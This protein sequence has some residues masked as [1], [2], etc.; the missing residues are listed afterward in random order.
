MIH[1]RTRHHWTIGSLTA[2]A[3]LTAAAIQPAAAARLTRGPY[4]Q[5][6]TAS[7]ITIRWRTDVATDARVQLGLSPA[8]LTT[9][10]AGATSGTEHSVTLSGLTPETRYYYS[11]G[12]AAEVLGGGTADYTFHT[13]PAPGTGRP[14][15][16]WVIGDSG[17]PGAD[18][19][20]V[21]NAFTGWTGSRDP[22]VWLMLGDNAYDSGTDSEY[23]EAVFDAYPELLRRVVLWPTR[24]NH[25][26]VGSGTDYYDI[27]TM[28]TAAQAGGVPSGTEAYYSFDYGDVHFIC[29]DSEG[30]SRS[31]T[32]AMARWVRND[33]SATDRSWII[34]YFHHP[35]YTKGSHDSDS[36][37]ELRDMR[38]NFV[39]I[40]EAGGVDL[41]LTGHSH[42]YERSF[43]LNGHTGT[44]GSLTNAMI[45]D[46]GDGRARGDGA[47][48]KPRGKVENRGAIY[49][50]A[51]SSSK[52][53][54]GSLDHPAMV[55]SLL[56]LGSM[57]LD[58]EG[59][60]LTARF[61]DENGAVLD[62]FALDK[63][64]EPPRRGGRVPTGRPR[65]NVSLTAAPNP[66]GGAGARLEY[67]LPAAGH[68]SVAVFGVDGR[69][70][71]SL[72]EGHAG[73]GR[74]AVDW[75]GRDASGVPVPEGIY[76][77]SVSFDGEVRV[78][79]LAKLH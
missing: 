78:R 46:G 55:V 22:D 51:G 60:T 27:F 62:D 52:T 6:G 16:I 29:L 59:T 75:N 49:A 48:K 40:L 41:V 26:D 79:R 43:L 76:F 64:Q 36:E 63:S 18:Q 39:P 58:V 65:G 47:Y 69:R 33:I 11:V 56:R 30:S 5:V 70:V 8:E 42:S 54:S 68:V 3:L 72:R 53:S 77:A 23:Q 74:H 71:V 19:Q 57:V 20:D 17:K 15:R 9:A 66:F 31:A 32:G 37:S 1:A 44:S 25:D 61:L 34:A 28:P 45:L 24:G 35:P 4:L 38:Q 21:K 14:T 67:V 50:V 73:E 10:V 2:C 13:A 7:S 12:S